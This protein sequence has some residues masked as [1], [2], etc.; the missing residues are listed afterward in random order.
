MSRAE[1]RKH[2]SH[3]RR[4]S[5]GP[6][7]GLMVAALGTTALGIVLFAAVLVARPDYLR[8]PKVVVDT[9]SQSPFVSCLLTDQAGV[10]R[11]PA[12][13]VWAGMQDAAAE[14]GTRA[15]FLPVIGKAGTG[16]AAGYLNTLLAQR[17]NVVAAVGAAPSAAMAAAAAKHPTTRF[18][19]VGARAQRSTNPVVIAID[20][21][22]A[23]AR[24]Y[25]MQA[26]RGK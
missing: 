8:S 25:V 1:Q 4:T 10:G 18:L 7:L 21:A 12:S 9:R 22:R 13:Q 5:K 14:T 23:D 11:A 17:C 24:A 19:V 26:V 20:T 3:D 16:N 2:R 6:D 15:N